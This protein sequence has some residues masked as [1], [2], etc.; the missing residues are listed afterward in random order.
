M[1]SRS[2]QPVRVTPLGSVYSGLRLA[3]ECPESNPGLASGRVMELAGTRGVQTENPHPYDVMVHHAHLAEVLARASRQPTGEPVTLHPAVKVTGTGIV[4]QPDSYLVDGGTR[5]MRVV[6]AASWDDDRQL[7]ELHSWRTVGDICT[8]GL[9]M[10]IRVLVIGASHNGKRHGHWSR[11]RQHPY[12]KSI[13]FQRRQAR[14]EFNATYKTVWREQCHIAADKW[15]EQMSRDGVLRE[16]AFTRNVRVPEGR[17]RD[18]VIEDIVRVAGEIGKMGRDH[19]QGQGQGQGHDQ[20]IFPL[21]P[22]TRSACDMA[23]PGRGP[24]LFQAVCYSPVEISPGETGLFRK[25]E[26]GTRGVRV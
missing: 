19:Y 17:Q 16:V 14:E 21:F 1:F 5:L 12:D 22:M 15:I 2:W 3:L 9:P 24:C 13:R 11:A 26:P 10:T 20:D 25:R 4:W 18:L 23:G 7:S 8:T 6:L